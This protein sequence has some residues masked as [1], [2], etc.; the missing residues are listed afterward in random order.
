MRRHGFSSAAVTRCA[1]HAAGRTAGTSPSH[2]CDRRH[3]VRRAGPIGLVHDGTSTP[4]DRL[5]SRERRGDSARPGRLHCRHDDSTVSLVPFV[6]LRRAALW[7]PVSWPRQPAARRRPIRMAN[8]SGRRPRPRP[9]A[10]PPAPAVPDSIARPR[11]AARGDPA[12]SPRTLRQPVGRVRPAD[13]G[14][15]RRREAHRGERA[16]DRREGRPRLRALP[17]D[18]SAARR[19]SARTRTRPMSY[20]RLRAMLDTMRAHGIYPIA[21]I[22]VAKDPLLAEHK[23]EWAI[24]RAIGPRSRGSTRTASRGSIRISAASGSTPRT[25]RR[26]PSTSASAKCSST[27]CASPTRSDSYGRPCF[28]SRT[29]VSARRSSASS[30]DSRAASFARP[31]CR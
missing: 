12:R 11:S 3:R 29:G 5:D 16:R 24:K 7:L 25:S 4:H 26:K 27:T 23:L 15:H 1:R 8:R 9:T 22:V 13:V 19:R 6:S 17:F 18:R 31:A 28:R 2:G 14:A 30:S 20:R 10:A 21:R